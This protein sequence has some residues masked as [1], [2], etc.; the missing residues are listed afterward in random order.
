[1]TRIPTNDTAA[2]VGHSGVMLKRMSAAEPHKGITYA[3]RDGYYIIGILR[4][5]CLHITVDFEEMT[6]NGP[7]LLCL[8][9]GHVHSL[10]GAGNADGIGIAIDPMLVNEKY[11]N[12]FNECFF[13]PSPLP[14]D[15]VQ[16][17]EFTQICGMIERKL[18]E[19]TPSAREI[20]RSLTDVLTGMAAEAI[21]ANSAES[22]GGGRYMRIM[23]GFNDLLKEEICRNRRVSY[24]AGRLNISPS[25]LNEAVK[26]ITGSSASR[27]IQ[28]RIILKVK[29]LL[30][31]TGMSI[32]QVAA[33]AGFD[34]S[35]YFSRLFVRTCG[36]SP[37]QFRRKYRE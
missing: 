18:A 27:Y 12:I 31:Y 33:D 2:M 34:D 14:M 22:C 30:A 9:P 36:E 29:R 11:R 19:N 4:S 1:M 35:A 7:A 28:N 26:A 3:H 24:Y 15:P 25:Y 17:R 32:Q 6:L 20:V 10:D 16:E 21:R 37:S 5:G 13:S 8:Q 23:A